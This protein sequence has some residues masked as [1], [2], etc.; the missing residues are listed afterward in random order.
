[1]LV[2][3]LIELWKT[4]SAFQ[5]L[6]TLNIP[7]YV[8]ALS[9]VCSVTYIIEGTYPAAGQKISSV[10]ICQRTMLVPRLG[11]EPTLINH[12]CQLLHLRLSVT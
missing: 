10:P 9:A 11:I 5:R 12:T 8:A 3:K 1:M 4:S 2:I 6:G 7:L